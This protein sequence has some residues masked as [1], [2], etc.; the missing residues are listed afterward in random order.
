MIA[1]RSLG[2]RQRGSN[3]G[4][5]R[6][7]SVEKAEIGQRR[8][9]PLDSV[10]NRQGLYLEFPWKSLEKF[11]FS[12]EMFGNPCEGLE[13][14]GHIQPAA[15]GRAP[16]APKR[17]PSFAGE[18]SRAELSYAAARKR[19]LEFATGFGARRRFGRNRRRRSS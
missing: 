12:L 17:A 16:G 3:S 13:K 14:F 5:F 6:R 15:P 2:A 8:R 10:G 11:G 19:R 1:P 9:Q 18:A 7:G 4:E